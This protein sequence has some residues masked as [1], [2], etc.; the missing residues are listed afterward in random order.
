MKSDKKT[1]DNLSPELKK[2]LTPDRDKPISQ[3]PVP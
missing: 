3:L 1:W 2:I